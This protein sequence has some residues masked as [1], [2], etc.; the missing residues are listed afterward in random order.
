MSIFIKEHAFSVKKIE[1]VANGWNLYPIK[2]DRKKIFISNNYY[3]GKIPP[4][5]R[6]PW[7]KIKLEITEV[8]NFIISASVN[9]QKLFEVKEEDC[10]LK[11]QEAIKKDKELMAKL[12]KA[13]KEKEAKKQL[14]IAE[15]KAT[16]DEFASTFP[17]NQNLED[18]ASNL[19]ICLRV[20]IKLHLFMG[21][22]T[23][24]YQ[25][26]LS[27]MYVLCK[28]AYKYYRRH[29]PEDPKDRFLVSHRMSLRLEEPHYT[30]DYLVNMLEFIEQKDSEDSRRIKYE[31][32]APYFEVKQLLQD[33]FSELKDAKLLN[34]LNYVVR[35]IIKVY[36]EDYS[37]L[38]EKVD[39]Y[40][41][42]G[43]PF[44]I[45]E[46]DYSYIYEYM[47][48]LKFSSDILPDVI[49]SDKVEYFIFN[50]SLR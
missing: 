36:H 17:I 48:L 46:K 7:Q 39:H 38:L 45:S 28:L 43:Q 11:V 24:N 25:Q 33:E 20:Y 3:K 30:D 34:Y 21:Q 1:K 14:F 13:E 27:L 40:N 42:R 12:E 15:I 29:V 18:E 35:Q 37:C 16:V 23:A 50:F 44:K 32:Y 5:F 47:E 49:P 8:E 31:Y 10:P 4:F 19:P 6:F 41:M 26:R 22:K 9:G 2:S